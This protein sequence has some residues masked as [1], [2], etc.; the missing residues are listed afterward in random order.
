MRPVQLTA[1]LSAALALAVPL[2]SAFAAEPVILTPALTEGELN[3]ASAERLE[4]SLRAAIRKSELE[5]IEIDAEAGARASA[6]ADDDCRAEALAAHGGH[7]LLVPT[8]AIDD[9]DYQMALTL[10]GP[11]GRELARLDESCGLCGLAEAADVFADLGARMGRKIDLAA[12]ASA[13]VITSDPP[14]AKVYVGDELLGTT[15]VELPLA[16]GSHALQIELDGY[17]GQRRDVEVVAGETNKLALTL[18]PN[19]S[20]AGADR[21]KAKLLGGL[22]WTALGLGLG[23]AGGGIALILIDEQPI[24]SDCSGDNVDAAGNC[25]WRHATLEP[26]IGLAIGGAVLLG[27]SVA[28]LLL[29]RKRGK[30]KSGPKSGTDKQARWQPRLGG[31]ALEF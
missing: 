5:L 28:L 22:G 27:G 1:A 19:P 4:T 30:S 10:Y 26:G 16:A 17:I 2:R 6:C 21:A 23:A 9:Q 8:L 25:R 29:A 11:S 13:I 31:L 3:P 7:Y 18:Q 14:G 15:P 24:T 20:E 12:Q